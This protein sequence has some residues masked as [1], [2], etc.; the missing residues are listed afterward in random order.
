MT[1]YLRRERKSQKLKEWSSIIDILIKQHR[2]SRT[3]N[4]IPKTK[5]KQHEQL[6]YRH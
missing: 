6:L 2:Q 5:L 1:K 4:Q 3:I